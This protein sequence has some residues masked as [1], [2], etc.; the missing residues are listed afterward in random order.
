VSCFTLEIFFGEKLSPG[1]RQ[2]VTPS[3]DLKFE[4]ISLRRRVRC[5]L[6]SRVRRGGLGCGGSDIRLTSTAYRPG[7]T[8]AVNG[9]W[10]SQVLTR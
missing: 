6:R 2:S 10:T 1:Y 5:E 9:M 8:A 3:R 4:S 7:W